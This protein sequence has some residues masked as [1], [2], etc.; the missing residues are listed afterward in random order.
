[1]DFRGPGVGQSI[2]LKLLIEIFSSDGMSQGIY[3]LNYFQHKLAMVVS[4]QARNI[5]R[6]LFTS[7]LARNS[8]MPRWLFQRKLASSKGA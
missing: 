1:M 6:W 5:V 2:M 7:T 4:T 8:A 3:Y